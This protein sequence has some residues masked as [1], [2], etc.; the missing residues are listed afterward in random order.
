[1]H[2]YTST[3]ISVLSQNHVTC[4]AMNT[5][6]IPLLGLFLIHC[7]IV[8]EL[9][10]QRTVFIYLLW[11]NFDLEYMISFLKSSVFIVCV[12]VF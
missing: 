6:D 7:K 3:Y 5:H 4:I 8:K 2:A 1:M 11:N 10:R 12:C 9:T